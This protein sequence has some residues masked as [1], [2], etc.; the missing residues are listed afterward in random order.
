MA[1]RKINDESNDEMRRGSLD[2][3][4]EKSSVARLRN[5]IFSNRNDGF[6]MSQTGGENNNN[7][8]LSLKHKQ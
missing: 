4:Q 6:K 3:E 1:V 8:M 2:D 7:K 5:A